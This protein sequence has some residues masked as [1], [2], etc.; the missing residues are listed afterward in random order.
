VA[1]FVRPVAAKNAKDWGDCVEKF[2]S[3]DLIGIFY[4]NLSA[5]IIEFS[6][7]MASKK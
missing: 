7:A 3:P 5:K 4:R 6:S 1:Q 2:A